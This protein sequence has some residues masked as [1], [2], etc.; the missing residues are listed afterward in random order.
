MLHNW[1]KEEI[2]K[3]IK[4]F[5]KFNENEDTTYQNL[6]NILKAV[7]QGKSI[8]LSAHMEKTEESHIRELTA[9]LKALEQK[10]ANSP[11]RS[12]R[13]EIIHLRAEINKVET[14]KTIQNKSMQ[15]RVG[16]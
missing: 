6:W 4:D 16:F 8:A 9:Q 13:Q 1:V 2:K 10:G 14:R 3:E 5:L 15:Q 7:L 12:R 11:Q